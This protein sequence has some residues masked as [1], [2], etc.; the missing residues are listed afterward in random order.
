[1]QSFRNAVFNV[2]Y[3]LTVMFYGLL[4][5]VIWPTP[6]LVRHKI[7]ATWTKF[8]IWWLRIC[9]HITHRITGEE[10]LKN[11]QAPVVVLS[12]HQSAWETFFLQTAFWPATTILKKELL[13][14]PFFGWGLRGLNPI[15]IDRSNPREALKQVKT[16]GTQRINE[17]Y[18]LIVFP[19][20]TRL[21]V[22]ERSKYARSGAD[23][24]V[25][26]GVDVIPVAH[27]AGTCWP[28]GKRPK[29]AGIIDIHIGKPIST[30]GKTSREV[31]E[32]VE[33]WIESTMATLPISQA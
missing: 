30:V 24:A 25:S 23:I 28:I 8:A 4:S 11:I 32:E 15:P 10:H 33:N 5:V 19:E 26:T 31:I 7:I 14:I 6:T 13:K 2:V 17:G 1:M 12:K 18:N 29:V 9:C 20:G 21:P 16:G 27:N 22:G 3:A